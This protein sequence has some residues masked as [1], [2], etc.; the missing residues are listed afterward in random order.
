MTP[1]LSTTFSALANDHR[2]EMV[3]LV[4]LQPRS[5]SSL[6]EVRGLSLP[7]IHK[8]VRVLEEAGL[9]RRRKVGRTNYLALGRRPLVELRTW[10]DGFEPGW[11]TD[12]ETLTNYATHLDRDSRTKEET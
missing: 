3:R 7:A 1:S 12:D 9:V 2:R 5:I 10:V 8:H 11:G 4:A 6:A